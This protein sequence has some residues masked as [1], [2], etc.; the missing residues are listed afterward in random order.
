M[1]VN[2]TFSLII[3]PLSVIIDLIVQMGI[4]GINKRSAS[5]SNCVEL[6]ASPRLVGSSKRKPLEENFKGLLVD[7]LEKRSKLDLMDEPGQIE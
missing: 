3:N 7:L 4:R 5:Q 1:T 6:G 2:R